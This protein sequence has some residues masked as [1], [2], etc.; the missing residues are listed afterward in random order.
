MHEFALADAV[1][2]TALRAAADAGIDHIDRVVVTVGELQDIR[3]DL[4]EFSLTQVIPLQDPALAE[5]EFVVEHEAAAF[6]CRVCGHGFG[7]SDLRDPNAEEAE[8]AHFVPELAHAFVR[9]PH[10]GSPDFEILAGRGVTLQRIE[11]R[12]AGDGA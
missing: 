9:C 3:A 1:V 12:G 10:C 11:G 7:L 6:G 8:A 4:F 5:A 2:T